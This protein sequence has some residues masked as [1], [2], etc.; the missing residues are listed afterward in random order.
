MADSRP[1]GHCRSRPRFCLKISSQRKCNLI[2]QVY[3]IQTPGEAELMIRLGVDHVGTVLIPDNGVKQE[4]LRDTIRTVQAAGSTSSLIPLSGNPETILS[5]LAYYRP[6]IVHFC[7]NLFG[8]EPMCEK[9]FELQQAV[10]TRFPGIRIMR[11]LPIPPPDRAQRVPTLELARRFEPVSDI[12]LTDTLIMESGNALDDAQP[13]S[14]FVGITG[15]T[16]DWKV[17]EKLV[18][19]SSIPVVLAG[20]LS[21]ENVRSGILAVRPA[22]V[23]SCTQ[24]NAIDQNGDPIRFKKDPDRVRAFVELAKRAAKALATDL[25]SV[26]NSVAGSDP[27]GG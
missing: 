8:P 23:D 26:G 1:F 4:V 14:G 17:A 6:D 10:R 5:A 11:S 7:E 20:G 22:G 24:T 19:Q 25:D 21:P 12:F 27:G 13:V 9:A 16:C 15:K 18:Q 3:E 2:I